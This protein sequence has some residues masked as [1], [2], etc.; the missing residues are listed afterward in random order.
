MVSCSLIPALVACSLTSSKKSSNPD[1]SSLNRGASRLLTEGMWYVV[2]AI[3]GGVLG[4]G[5]WVGVIG[6][7]EFRGV[8]VDERVGGREFSMR[9]GSSIS[10][11]SGEWGAG[12]VL[13]TVREESGVG[14]DALGS[15]LVGKRSCSMVC[16]VS[17]ALVASMKASRASA[18]TFSRR[19]WARV[20]GM[21]GGYDRL[22]GRLLNLSR[23]GFQ[24]DKLTLGASW[25]A[26]YRAGLGGWV[27]RLCSQGGG[28]VQ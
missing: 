25:E 7:R 23:R 27:L 16:K 13:S 2:L 14:C 4:K 28:T 21:A 26:C 18:I 8:G 15:R 17:T 10:G 24:I 6:D 9:S 5:G 12:T 20:R 11:I 19:V 1:A 22:V 3:A